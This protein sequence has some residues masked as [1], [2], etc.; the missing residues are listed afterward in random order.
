MVL[1]K[2]KGIKVSE[3]ATELDVPSKAIL[4][5]LHR[6][7]LGETIKTHNSTMPFGLAETVRTDGAGELRAS[8]GGGTATAV[9]EAPAEA[10][11]PTHKTT[12]G[13][14]K[15][16]EE[17]HEEV[18]P[19]PAEAAP[20]AP[21]V[22]A[23]ASP[24]VE[25]EPVAPVAEVAA[26]VAPPIEPAP[27]APAAPPV[28]EV[29]GEAVLVPAPA[30][31]AA[32]PPAV[33]VELAPPAET[34]AAAAEAP[35]PVAPTKKP[36]H[37]AH[38]KAAKKELPKRAPV[39]PAPQLLVPA[40][41]KIQG[42]RVVREEAPD[43]VA[44]PRPRR[45]LGTGTGPAF[46]QARPQGGRGVRSSTDEE[47]STDDT[48]EKKKVG[49]AKGRAG[50][51][52][53]RRRGL[54]GRRGEAMEKLREYSE[55]DLQERRNRLSGAS[56][57]RS[58]FDNTLKRSERGH[59]ARAVAARATI[60]EVEEPVTV[61]NLA[62]AL[63]I[64]A[65]DLIMKLMRQGVMANINQSLDVD[66]AAAMSLEYGLELKI[67]KQATLEEQL[68]KEF[69]ER[70][71][72]PANL[73]TRPPVV[74]IL[75][76]VDHG[77]T[78][79]LD[80]IR[81]TDVAAGEAGGITQHTAAWMVT[82]GEG[83]AQKRVTFIDTPG[84]QAFTSMR[85]RGANMTDVVVLV[86]AA[87]EGVQPQTI[88]SINHA[89]AAG[90]PIVVAMNK[91][92]RTDS[93]PDMVL[94]Q[95]AAQNLNPV[96][97]GGD[98]EVVRTSATTGQGIQDL[99]EILDYQSQL[100]DLKADP[101]APARGVV[102]ESFMDEGLGPV[103]TVLVQDGTL[104]RGD[105]LLAGSGY[106]RIRSLLNDRRQMID[107][108]GPS[109]PVIVSGLG[110]LP[111]AG[112]KFYVVDD[113]EQARAITEERQN[114]ARQEQLAQRN[115]VTLESIL[116]S[117]KEQSVKEIR[118]IIKG[119]VQGSVET[120]SATVTQ[121]NTN[122]VKIRVIHTAVGPISESDVELADAS[123]AVIIGF[124]V[125]PDDAARAMAEQRRVEIRLYRVIYELLDDLKKALSG[126]L[127]PEVREKFHG[128]AEI[129]QVYKFSKVGN[130][131]GCMVVDGHIQRGSKIRL[132]RNG[133]IVTESLTIETLRRIK[134]DVREV[135]QGFECGIKLAGY[136]DIKQ[137]DV[138][139][140]YVRE[141]IHRT[142]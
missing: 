23:S 102:V 83:D 110:S 18:A 101:T 6:N 93:N 63:K 55:A 109:T 60:V 80:K 108:A 5:W 98:V 120:L 132:I 69:D 129:R 3:L 94:G 66:T 1:A 56:S 50:T 7:G 2:V 105:V 40:P 12:R 103:A 82:V 61:K 112:D 28:E 127:E 107:E 113:V 124:H 20:A 68:E 59:G 106:G 53:S 138:L 13:H 141:L 16:G 99:I 92:D 89:R 116:G 77:K 128:R 122:E 70:Q 142:L 115:Q 119:D 25:A 34:P 11:R 64:K 37:P 54:D 27:E 114:H 33:P 71:P 76:H 41:A 49:P 32:P 90:V 81:H 84:H 72:D 111:D 19:E 29:Q 4:E 31:E 78:S 67:K 97:W 9:A 46:V 86:V 21:E 91:I 8:S 125:A 48:A 57:Y 130:I 140:G 24:A 17:G 38:P 88:E 30:L 44:A 62:I 51:L 134:E 121:A 135:K 35:A 95:L 133:T 26:P 22:E 118:L 85:A 42:P 100:L 58:S 45:P 87:P 14:K 15:K 126:L 131:A 10:E 123:D 43:V 117:M 52:S 137:G 104:K 47:G 75:G 79:L 139:E 36:A 39:V 65:N 73:V 74:T 136:D 96:E